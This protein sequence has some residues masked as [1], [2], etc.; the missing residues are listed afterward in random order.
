MTA[1]ARVIRGRILSF[2]DDPAAVRVVGSFGRRRRRRSCRGRTDRGGRRGARHSRPRASRRARRRSCRLN[3]HRRLHRRPRPL[4]ADPG[5]RLLRRATARL[6]QQL[7]V[8]RGAEICRPRPLRADRRV[9]PRRT[10]PLRHDDRD[11]LLHSA[12]AI[13]RRVLRR[14]REARRAHDRRQGH[15]GPRRAVEALMD[16]RSA[17][18]R[19]EQGAD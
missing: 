1:N 9:L 17:R 3:R 7:H 4:S 6:A 14:G 15:D 18:L 8:R 11:G 16:T 12:S 2:T 19:R 5:D 10:H 13:C